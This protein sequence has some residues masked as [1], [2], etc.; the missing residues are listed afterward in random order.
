MSQKKRLKSLNSLNKLESLESHSSQPYLCD[1]LVGLQRLDV[2][3]EVLCQLC[4]AH[5]PRQA[6]HLE[7]EEPPL[8]LQVARR[9]PALKCNII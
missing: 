4:L 5:V 1:L 3:L 6:L 7:V 9:L 8:A 2:L